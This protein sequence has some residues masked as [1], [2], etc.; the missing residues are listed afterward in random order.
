MLFTKF[1]RKFEKEDQSS[2]D[3]FIKEYFNANY[4]L[5]EKNF[6]NW[7]YTTPFSS[8]SNLLVIKLKNKVCGFLGVIPLKMNYFG[9]TISDSCLANLMTDKIFRNKGLGINF[10]S[11]GVTG[12]DIAHTTGHSQQMTNLFDKMNWTANIPLK[13]Y[14]K[15]LNQAKAFQLANCSS[16]SKNN[17]FFELSPEERISS[18]FSFK[19]IFF[20]DEEIDKFWYK[21]KEKYPITIERTSNYLNWRYSN[22]PLLNYHIFVSKKNDEIKSFIILRIEELQDHKIGRIIDFISS[23]KAEFFTLS[24]LIQYCR[25]KDF[26]LIDFFFNGNFH[27]QSLK[28]AGFKEARNEPYSLI[29]ILFNPINRERKTINFGFKLINQELY[30]E[31]INNLNNWYITKGDGD[32]DRPNILSKSEEKVETKK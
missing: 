6:L 4:I 2:F 28:S 21:V 26:T 30:D 1:I 18:N 16:D 22:H 8:E 19:E 11:S 20:F 9:K 25:E 3:E 27:L 23:D 13:R 12:F 15:I 14:L 10:I 7:Q 24:N 29:P 31:R 5:L 17:H 32:Q